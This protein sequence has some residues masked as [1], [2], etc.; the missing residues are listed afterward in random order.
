MNYWSCT[1]SSSF[2]LIYGSGNCN[3]HART[4]CVLH[5]VNVKYIDVFIKG[6]VVSE[7]MKSVSESFHYE[8]F[9]VNDRVYSHVS[10]HTE[11]SNRV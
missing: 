5:N 11:V 4:E 2:L 8:I 3:S 6:S 10:A 1:D 7:Q 9:S